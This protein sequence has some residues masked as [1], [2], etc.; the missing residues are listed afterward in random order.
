MHTVSAYCNHNHRNHLQILVIGSLSCICVNA[1]PSENTRILVYYTYFSAKTATGIVDAIDVASNSESTVKL[2][3][4]ILIRGVRNV[5]VKEAFHFSCLFRKEWIKNP[6]NLTLLLR[7]LHLYSTRLTANT[8]FQKWR[9]FSFK[10]IEV[11]STEHGT[12][13]P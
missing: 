8:H 6:R 3:S 12:F 11:I 10:D 9:I 7:S 13:L 4:F 5:F 1:P 2:F